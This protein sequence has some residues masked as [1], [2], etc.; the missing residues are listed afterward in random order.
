[1]ENSKIFLL[2]HA[3]GS[4]FSRLAQFHELTRVN[5]SYFQ[6]CSRPGW[7]EAAVKHEPDANALMRKFGRKAEKFSLRCCLHLIQELQSYAPCYENIVAA[8]S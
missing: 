6:L 3:K 8:Y 2:L 7:E 4:P 5:R 1:M